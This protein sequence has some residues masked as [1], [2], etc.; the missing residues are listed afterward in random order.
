MST[1]PTDITVVPAEGGLDDNALTAL[2][3]T[4]ADSPRIAELRARLQELPS[5]DLQMFGREAAAK[6]SEFSS[7]LLDQV[8]NADLEATGEKLGEVVRIARNLNLDRLGA[9]S[10]VP[11]FGPLIDRL[12]S[13]RG[14][15]VQKFSSTNQQIDQLMRDVSVQ[16]TELARRVKDF[17]RMHEIVLAERHEIG[18]HIA[19]GK[20]RLAELESQR[21]P[22]DGLD[23]PQSR[24]QRAEIDRAYRLLHKRVGD[25]IVL[26]HAADQSA[27]MIRIIQTNAM[28]LI[29]K[30][31]A[32]RDI[33]IPAWKRGF[34]I[35]LS[36]EEQKNAVGLANA[37]DDATNE[38]MRTNAKLLRES[39]VATAKANQRLVIDVETL[40]FVHEQLIGT[41]EDVRAIHREGMQKREQAGR[42]LAQLR[43]EV[44]RR[45]AAPT[46]GE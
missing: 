17:D 43:E 41:V 15:L 21:R 9:R 10:R 35:Q 3:L 39:S 4:A 32:V 28:Q 6:T 24:S 26:Q 33:T 11:V 29:E 38:M 27:P 23:D 5:G 45:L 19:A 25:L 46:A 13:S 42:E 44:Q 1:T 31:S 18:L 30:F 36:L 22:L 40:K 16:Q 7:Q 2:G 8:R 14:E 12:R 20:M 37:I 34:A